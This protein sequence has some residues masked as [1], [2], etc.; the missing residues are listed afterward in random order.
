VHVVP[1][2]SNYR[3]RSPA[4]AGPRFYQVNAFLRRLE[5]LELVAATGRTDPEV[6]SM[7]YSI[8]DAGLAELAE[9]YEPDPPKL[10]D[11]AS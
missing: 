10:N 7:E 8:T 11:D 6:R 9:R 5:V 3:L 2:T 1:P 4:T